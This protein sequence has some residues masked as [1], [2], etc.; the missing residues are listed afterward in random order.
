[1]D[2]SEIVMAVVWITLAIIVAVFAHKRGRSSTVWLLVALLLS[3]LIAF[4]AV[5]VMEPGTNGAVP[6]RTCP[7]CAERIKAEARVCRYCAR[8]LPADST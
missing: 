1:M 3:P 6:H 8:E 5:A 4:I 2:D 7:F